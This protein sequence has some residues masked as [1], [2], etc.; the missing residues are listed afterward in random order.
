MPSVSENYG[1]SIV[2]ALFAG[3]PVTTSDNVPWQKLESAKAGINVDD[4]LNSLSTAIERFAA[5][6]DAEFQQWKRGARDYAVRNTNVAEV[7]SAHTSMF[8]S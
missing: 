4:D 3:L 7:Y 5:M 6:P 8:E 2:E 1:H